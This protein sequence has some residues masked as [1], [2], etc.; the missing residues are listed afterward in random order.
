MR[1]RD[2]L[3]DL[4]EAAKSRKFEILI[5][6]SLDRLSRDPEDLAGIY[7]RL[8]FA[9][10]ELHTLNE[11]VADGMK[12]G[13]RS[14]MGAAFLKDLADKVRRHH[15]ARA[16]EGH[17]M[18]MVTYGY[19]G[20]DGKPGEREIDPQSAPIVRR[21]F[22]EYAN[23]ISPRAIAIGLTRDNI[24]SP[25]GAEQWSHQSFL[26]GGGKKGLL[27]NSLYVG[28]LIYNKHKNVS[29][30]DGGTTT[31][32]NPERD[33]IST[34]VPHLRIIDQNL[35]DAAQ[36]IR[37][38]RS[39]KQ[40]GPGGMKT[41]KI[42][43]RSN[44]LLSGLLRCGVCHEK[45]M[46]TSTSR[47]TQYVACGAW[48]KNSSCSHGK[49]YN[50]DLLQDIVAN[51]WHEKLSAPERHKKAMKAAV[52]EYAALAKKNN[53]DKEVVKAK[54]DHLTVQ[55]SRLADAIASGNMPIKEVMTAIEEKARERDGLTERLRLIN[56]SSPNSNVRPL[57]HV[58]DTY[59]ETVE[60]VGA[61][62]KTGSVSPDIVMA[63]QNLI[64]T[65]V[66]HPTG[67]K[68]PYEIE[69]YGRESAYLGINLFPPGKP[70]EEILIEE[71]VSVEHRAAAI[72][73]NA[74][75]QVQ[76]GNTGR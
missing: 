20:V 73:A 9:E 72:S 76:R 10:I 6:E 30:P 45:M 60:N 48:K 67:Y 74:R 7:K 12:I 65:I 35:W 57:P 61:A 50:V 13:F 28:K 69:V 38:D 4:M 43:K 29:N 52:A 40:F 39:T 59:L 5:V 1:G 66:V 42:I 15:V 70:L 46:F 53:V 33:H 51:N 18:G 32:D 56:A 8:S 23:G 25:S 49:S 14:I 19:R 41:R 21:I 71:G 31:R 63:F 55:I 75:G 11:G 16:K 22:T 17:V 47:G 62:L 27:A 24:P 44:H 36:T 54:V 37:S 26:G 3:R 64:D 2:G 58:A 34:D 68:Q